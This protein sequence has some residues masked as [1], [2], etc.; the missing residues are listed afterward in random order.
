METNNAS[1]GFDPIKEAGGGGEPLE[2]NCPI[3]AAASSFVGVQTDFELT[4]IA[5]CLTLNEQLYDPHGPFILVE[6]IDFY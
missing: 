4:N 1:L 6:P 2:L 5:I 3:C